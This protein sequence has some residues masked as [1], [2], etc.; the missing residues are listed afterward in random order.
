MFTTP[1]E[2]IL[3]ALKG[4]PAFKTVDAWMGDVDDLMEQVQKLPSA[5]LLM[6][7]AEF[8]PPAT[9]G[10]VAAPSETTWSIIVI[11]EQLRDRKTGLVESLVLIESLL[12]PA[13]PQ[14][15]G[16]V[17]G[18]TRLKTSSGH[19]WPDVVQFLGAKGGKSAYG[20]KFS[21]ENGR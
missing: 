4:I 3:A 12:A 7:A 21:L 15:P 1:L 13:V 6:S 9:I 18:L 11:S 16:D 8:D 2:Q 20:L 10:A 5:H 14:A 17:R 19:L